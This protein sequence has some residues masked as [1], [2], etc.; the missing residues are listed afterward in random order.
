[1]INGPCSGHAVAVA[2][3]VDGRILIFGKTTFWAVFLL[4]PACQS[5]FAKNG[6]IPHGQANRSF[7]VYFRTTVSCSGQID[8]KVKVTVLLLEMANG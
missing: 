8:S 6:T 5:L 4:N 3:A 1:M 7:S 2:V